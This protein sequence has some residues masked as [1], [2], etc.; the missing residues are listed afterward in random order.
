MERSIPAPVFRPIVA[1]A[2]GFLAVRIHF[3]V[4]L[5]TTPAV[6]FVARTV[7]RGRTLSAPVFDL[8]S[9]FSFRFRFWVKKQETR[10]RLAIAGFLKNLLFSLEF[11]SHD[12]K[13]KA[14][15]L[16]NRHASIGL[17]MLQSWNNHDFH[18]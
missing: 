16:P 14:I 4:W 15:A 10:D 9:C 12:A 18:F 3:P 11:C 1:Q 6:P 5:E 8:C 17:H 7:F 13:T 2:T